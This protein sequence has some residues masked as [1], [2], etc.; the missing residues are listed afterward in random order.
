MEPLSCN[1]QA[2][3]APA[4]H[5]PQP[6]THNSH[7]LWLGIKYV[8]KRASYWLADDLDEAGLMAADL[9]TSMSGCPPTHPTW[10]RMT[11]S[12]EAENPQIL[13]TKA[14]FCSKE[15]T[16]LHQC[17][18]CFLDCCP[19]GQSSVYLFIFHYTS[20]TTLW[21]VRKWINFSHY[22]FVF[23]CGYFLYS[24]LLMRYFVSG[25]WNFSSSSVLFGSIL[26]L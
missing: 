22:V 14:P 25:R 15:D 20:V 4:L 23:M 16:R 21:I 24:M 18:M 26:S 7:C 1:H 8:C 11:A 19:K 9:W 3:I 12:T 5:L 17:Q 10:Q 2:S 6:R 13:E